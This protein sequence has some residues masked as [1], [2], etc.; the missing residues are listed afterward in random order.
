[1]AASYNTYPPLVVL[2]ESPIIYN[3]QDS[4]ADVDKDSYQMMLDLFVWKGSS[5]AKP[6][7]PLFTLSKYPIEHKS[8]LYYTA[9]F[10]VSN[11]VD[12]YMTSSLADVYENEESENQLYIAA[13]AYS[14]WKVSNSY[15]TSSH[16]SGGQRTVMNGY[17]L[18]GEMELLQSSSEYQ[19]EDIIN[20]NPII[21]SLP[22]NVS[23]SLSN[24]SVPYYFSVLNAQQSPY[25]YPDTVEVES[26]NGFSKTFTLPGAAS[27]DSSS[28]RISNLVIS[29]SDWDSIE[30]SSWVNITAY[31]GTTPY[32]NPI[33][34]DLTC[35][36]KY[37]PVRI[38]FKNR[39]G[40]FDN[41]EFS[42]V[43][44]NTFEVDTKEFKSN[45]LNTDEAAYNRYNGTK[46]YYS[47]GVETLTVNSDYID[48]S[49]NDFFKQM[50]ASDEI[51]WVMDRDDA[52]NGL[53]ANLQPLTLISKNL[54]FKKQEVDKLI[55]Y[56]LTFKYGTPYKLTL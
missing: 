9:N 55:N 4:S 23:Q 11:I 44:Q 19:I 12:S 53:W 35:Q 37:T 10:D 29:G 17:N 33:N 32:D 49:F 15:V 13:E 52:D 14:R 41:F 46:T 47:D 30:G 51:Y 38:I 26:S 25:V 3:L 16:Q 24:I 50:M 1:M 28:L 6:A 48:E 21:S 34:I 2:S 42:L 40:A 45:A 43:S 54:Q 8:G 18:W 31:D 5:S 39:F 36:K 7:T 56:Q 27:Y 20:K 22:Q